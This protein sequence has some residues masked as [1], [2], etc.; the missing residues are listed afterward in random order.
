MS[1]SRLDAITGL[2][3]CWGGGDQ[4]ALRRLIPLVYSELYKLSSICS[5]RESGNQT[6][7]AT[8]LVNE[9]YVRLAGI[10]RTEFQNRAHFYGAAASIIR[11]ILVAGH[12]Q[13]RMALR[14]DLALRTDV[15][16]IELAR[17][18]FS[19]IVFVKCRCSR[20]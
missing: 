13:A 15:R 5:S 17:T 7:D 1:S 2:L 14:S 19:R 8:G 20:P 10:S 3:P 6:M 18:S 16:L 4:E 9:V 11:R 12:R